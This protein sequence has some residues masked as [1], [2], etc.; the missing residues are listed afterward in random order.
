MTEKWERLSPRQKEILAHISEGKTSQET[1]DVLYVS[2]RTV[3][4]HLSE[5]YGKLGVPNRFAA[6]A[7]TGFLISIETIIETS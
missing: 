6:L 7:A 4:F 3:D 5:I 2:K 1:A